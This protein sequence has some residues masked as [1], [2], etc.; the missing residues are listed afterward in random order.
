MKHLTRI[1]MLLALVASV[2]VLTGCIPMPYRT[3]PTEVGVRTVKWSLL[4]KAGVEEK[5]Y[6]P[7]TTHWF[8]PFFT[9][10][11]T[12]D[13]RLQ[14]LEMTAT[15]ERGDR[16]GRDDLL[17]KTVDGNDISL[18]V[19]ISYKIIKER[20]PEI[21]Q[22]VALN[23]L[24]LR[25]NIVRTITRSK[26]RDI[27]GELNTE[28]LYI[29]EN[30]TK[31]SEDVQR[32]LNEILLP[33]GVEVTQVGTRDYRFN[34]EYQQAI[35]EKKVADQEAEKLKSETRAVAEEFLTEVERAKAQNVKIEQ[36]ADGEYRRAVIEADAYFEQ[37]TSIAQAILAEAKAQAEGIREMNAALAG[38]GGE[39]MVKLKLAEALK[40][41]RIIMLPTGGEGGMDVRSTNVNQLL[42]TLGIQQLAKPV[43]T[44]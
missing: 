27:F 38:T 22:N 29:A 33:Y 24:E 4:G 21:L 20:A 16:S 31:K 13:T 26:P 8:V 2:P 1:T 35:E 40:D 10:W 42:E 6:E 15:P 37:Q 23:D 43:A 5:V 34:P 41:K 18:D 30:R 14:N 28:E 11:H 12:Y 19:I 9:D 36:E 25:E 3:G 44:P 39:M 17:F 32:V 7:G